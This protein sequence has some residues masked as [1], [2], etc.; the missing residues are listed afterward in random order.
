MGLRISGVSKAY[1]SSEGCGGT[2]RKKRD[3][4]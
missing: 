1:Y 4:K 3:K 2:G